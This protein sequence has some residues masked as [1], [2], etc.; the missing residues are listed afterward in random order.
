VT[1]TVRDVRDDERDWVRG[2]IRER[3]GSAIAVAHGVAYEPATLPGFVAEDDGRAV[4]LLTYHV[5]AGACE[6]VT[7]DAFE[8]RRGVGTALVEAVRALGH[9]RVW[10]ITTNDNVRAQRFYERTGFRPVAVHEGAVE[11]SRAIKPE[12]PELAEEGT[13]IRDELEYEWRA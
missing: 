3:W 12:I 7:I 2:V 13:P 11:R 10:L 1:V 9:A 5:Q 8:E 4:G 6:I